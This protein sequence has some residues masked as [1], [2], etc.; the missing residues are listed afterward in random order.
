MVIKRSD[1]SSRAS[2]SNDT[3]GSRRLSA[4]RT[5]AAGY[6]AAPGVIAVL[7][8]GSTGR[9][10]A[11]RWS[12]VEL[13]VVWDCLPDDSARRRAAEGLHAKNL[14]L[15]PWDPEERLWSDDWWFDGDPGSGL[16]VEISHLTVDGVSQEVDALVAGNAEPIRIGFGAAL[17]SGIDMNGGDY[18]A[19]WRSRL[20]PY[21]R[22]LMI[23]VVR[24]HAQIDHFWRWQMY[25]DRGEAYGL[26]SHF[27]DVACRLVQVTC[28][29]SGR[30]WPGQKYMLRIAS[31]LEL[32]PTDFAERLAQVP[33]EAPEDAAK[34]M[35]AIVEEVYDLVEAHLPEVDVQRLRSIFHFARSPW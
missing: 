10:D 18:L 33:L 21:P 6:A 15:F 20:D 35:A 9:G 31:R 24:R 4:A 14:R 7:C 2:G 29:L 22:N 34:S 30:W 17:V 8:A 5:I 12:D 13:V 16:L 28:A 25:V 23:A 27:V 11:D 3:P 1:L 19:S 32:A 26:Q